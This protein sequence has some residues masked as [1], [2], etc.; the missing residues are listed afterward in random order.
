[1]KPSLSFAALLALAACAPVVTHSPRVEPGLAFHAT[2]GVPL[3]LCDSCGAGL[4]PT[5]GAGVR[6]GYVPA[7]P[8]SPSFL[9][10]VT[11]PLE[12]ASAELDAFVQAPSS[13]D[14]VVGAGTLASRRHVH[15]Y[16]QLGRI[17]AGGSG[18]YVGAGYAWLFENPDWIEDLNDAIGGDEDAVAQAPRYFAPSL[19]WRTT[20]GGRRFHAYLTGG[21]GSWRQRGPALDPATGEYTEA[22]RRIRTVMAGVSIEIPLRDGP[23][24]VTREP[25]RDAPS[26]PAPARPAAP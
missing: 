4:T 26:L 2:A 1:M 17:P 10:G 24:T 21:F 5:L 18:W 20:R 19:G 6:Y 11:A 15:P 22:E 23:P 9:V 14:W 8:S 7:D 12:A 16:V 25:V 3:P 13:G